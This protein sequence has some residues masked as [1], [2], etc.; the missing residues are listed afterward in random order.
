MVP[1]RR[2]TV[3]TPDG[4]ELLLDHLDVE[5]SRVRVLILHG[6]EGSSN[7]VYVQGTI[8]LLRRAGIS[9]TV[10]NFRSCARDPN[11]LGAV[12]LNR[13][14]RLYHSG[15]TTD[16]DF[17]V[18]LL[19]SRSNETL[20][21]FGVSLGGNVLLKWLGEHPDERLVSRAASVS[22]PYDLAAGARYLEGGVG[23]FYVKLFLRSLASKASK[24]IERFPEVESQ[25]DLRRGA[26]ASTFWEFDDAVTAPLHGFKGADDYYEQS[27]SIRFI[28]R[29]RVPTLCIS[30]EDDPFLPPAVLDRLRKEASPEVR[31]K[32]TKRG[33]HV[34]FVSGTP[35]R[36]RYWAE[37]LAAEWLAAPEEPA[38]IAFDD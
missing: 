20:R 38:G 29:I 22:V 24:V 5:L 25:I 37:E 33:G 23:R 7:S 16:L 34:G 3:T 14:C 9:S 10:L 35:W 8:D 21:A 27:S 30:A 13:A 19:R 31:L 36:P 32:V 17:V 15:E 11:D 2:E 28:S 18:R 4:D 6:L 12:V 1:L 26:R